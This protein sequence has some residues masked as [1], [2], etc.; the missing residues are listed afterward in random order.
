MDKFKKPLKK[1]NRFQSYVNETIVGFFVRTILLRFYSWLTRRK[2]KKTEAKYW[3]CENKTTSCSINPKITWIGHASFLIQIGGVN[4]LTDP[5][6]REDSLL[7]PRHIPLGVHL[8]KLPNID[9]VLLSHNHPDHMDSKSLML[10]KDRNK[11]N[12]LVPQGD[13]LWFDN[14]NFACVKEY[15]WWEKSSFNLKYDESKQIKFTF[16]PANHWSKRSLF[17][18]K[19]SSLWGSWMI[20]CNGYKIYFAGDTTYETHFATIARKFKNIDIV[21]M[22]IG[23]CEPKSW[24]GK[25]HI[26]PTEAGQAFL[27]LKAKHLIPMHWGT[28]PG[29]TELFDIPVLRLKNWWSKKVSLLKGKKL[30]VAKIGQC[31]EIAASVKEDVPEDVFITKKTTS[32]ENNTKISDIKF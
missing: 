7:F 6:L 9:F 24:V 19:N 18:K 4:I 22:P 3:F 16:L 21:L 27:D 10:L 1:N 28:F 13:K 29:G 17:H 25:A 30:H 11:T 5:F 26:G 14:K 12:F 31:F 15:T 23:P 8:D 20:E 32:F 2:A